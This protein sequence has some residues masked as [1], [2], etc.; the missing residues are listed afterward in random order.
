[1]YICICNAVTESAIKQAVR[2]GA[3]SVFDLTLRTGCSTQCGSCTDGVREILEASLA[4][5]GAERVPVK[6]KVVARN[7]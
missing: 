2:E 3:R 1:M 5:I 6:L 7:G 4:E